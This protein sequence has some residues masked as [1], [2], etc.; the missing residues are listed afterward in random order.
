MVA[1]G[2]GVTVLPKTA[3]NDL[4]PDSQIAVVPFEEPAP[5][6]RVIIVWRKTFSRE[7]AIEAVQK[8]LRRLKP[9]GCRILNLPP[10]SS[11]ANNGTP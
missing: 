11:V 3:L 6:R 5:S 4:P 2:L 8:A 10:V 1:Q 7:A 9:Q